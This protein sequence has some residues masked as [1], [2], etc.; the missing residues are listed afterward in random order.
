MPGD[1]L[2]LHPYPESCR[3]HQT[4]NS[5]ILKR[6][7]AYLPS[8]RDFAEYWPFAEPSRFQP[9]ANCG[10][11]TPETTQAGGL[12]ASGAL[13]PLRTT[14]RDDQ[15]LADKLQVG[16]LKRDEFGAA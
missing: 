1:A 11:C 15:T 3:L 7:R 12:H 5:G 16:N 13:R 8:G 2:G 10:C 4:R 6:A 9:C 14:N